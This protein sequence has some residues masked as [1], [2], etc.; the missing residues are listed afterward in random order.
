VFQQCPT[1]LING[2]PMGN[3]NPTRGIRQRDPLL[4]FLF[5]LY[6]EGLSSLLSNVEQHG[7]ITSIPIA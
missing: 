7:L 6:A 4:P 2:T 3:I 5:L 1:Q